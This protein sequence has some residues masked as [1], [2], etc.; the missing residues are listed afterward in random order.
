[1]LGALPALQS[2]DAEAAVASIEEAYTEGQ[3]SGLEVTVWLDRIGAAERAVVAARREAAEQRIEQA[4][5]E[6]WP[7]L[8][9]TTP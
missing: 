5:A 4:L 9:G 6:E 3:L 2:S 8:L 1:V 7:T